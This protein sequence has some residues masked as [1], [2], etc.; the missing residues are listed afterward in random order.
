M[1]RLREDEGYMRE[2]EEENAT[3][4]LLSNEDIDR[5]LS[6]KLNS[7]PLI[8][9]AGCY[10]KHQLDDMNPEEGKIYIINLDE[11]G[12]SGTHWVLVSN[13]NK[14]SP[15]QIVYFNSF[16]LPPPD[17]VLRFMKRAK[18]KN[19][20]KKDVLY[21]TVQI[22]DLE[23]VNC[24]YYVVYVTRQLCRGNSMADIIG[25]FHLGFDKWYNEYLINELKKSSMFAVIRD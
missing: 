17:V 7:K 20:R 4:S 25:R 10:M 6:N 2:D 1:N 13:I 22:Q 19:G 3:P 14:C 23:S 16:G 8:H 5:L 12:G 21:N 11:K 24:G 9:Y 15:K 18:D